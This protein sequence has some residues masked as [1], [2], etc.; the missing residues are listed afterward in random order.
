[1][2]FLSWRMLPCVVRPSIQEA[3]TVVVL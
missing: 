2:A 1:M 3:L